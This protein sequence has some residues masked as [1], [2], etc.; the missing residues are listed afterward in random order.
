MTRN[1]SGTAWLP[2]NSPMYAYMYHTKNWMY[3]LHGDV[4]VRYNKQ[5]LLDKG[6]RGGDHFDAPQIL[7]SNSCNS[8]SSRFNSAR[9]NG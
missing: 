5:D 8:G 9:L 6:R 4:Y 1:G 7:T 3:M 2:D